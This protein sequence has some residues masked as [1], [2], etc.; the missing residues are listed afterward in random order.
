LTYITIKSFLARNWQDFVYTDGSKKGGSSPLGGPTT[1]PATDARVKIMVNSTPPSHTI[2]SRAELAGIDIGLQLGHAYLLTDSAC[3][4]L[5]IQGY[6]RSP[7]AYRHHIHHDTLESNTITLK[8]SCT[9]GIRYNI[10]KIKAYNHSQGID[11]ADALS[12]QVAKGHRTDTTYSKGSKLYIG[13]SIQP[14]AI[15]DHPSATRRPHTLLQV[16]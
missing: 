11:L 4:L 7:T 15:L 5:L 14:M 10:C 8:T 12:D 1:H 2:N 13:T 9:S 3:S 6:V 16:H